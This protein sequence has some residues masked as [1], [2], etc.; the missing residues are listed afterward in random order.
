MRLYGYAVRI[1][2]SGSMESIGF[3]SNLGGYVTAS[4]VRGNLHPHSPTMED[5]RLEAAVHAVLAANLAQW[6]DQ[7]SSYEQFE[8]W[9][10]STYPEHTLELYTLYTDE[11]DRSSV[12][13]EDFTPP[14]EDLLGYLNALNALCDPFAA[15]Q[16]GPT[17]GSGGSLDLDDG[18]THQEESS[19]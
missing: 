1:T 7:F 18:D 11:L 2:R 10:R 13:L 12:Y 3:Y 8:E 5:V 16:G 9:F 17:D 4:G 6:F 15:Q 14:P 19:P